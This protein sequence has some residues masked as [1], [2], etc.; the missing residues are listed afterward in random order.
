MD[1]LK[2]VKGNTFETVVEIRAYKYNGEEITDF[3]LNNCTN[4]S[5]INHV[6]N[7]ETYRIVNYE[8]LDEKHIQMRWD[9]CV[10]GDYSLEVTGKLG[11]DYWRFYDKKPIFSIVN[12]NAE[13]HIPQNSIIREDCYQV[14]KQKVYIVCPKGDKGDKGDKGA[15]GPT[16][17]NG[18]PFKYEDFTQEQLNSLKGK[19]GDPG[20]DGKD[21]SDGKSAYELAVE[22]GYEGTLEQWLNSL[23]GLD[24][25]DGSNGK[26]AY[27][28]YVDTTSDDPV[29]TEEQWIA[30]LHGV[31]GSAFTYNDFTPAQLAVLKGEPGKDGH[32]PEIAASKSGDTTTIYLDGTSIATINDGQDGTN[33]VSPTISVSQI[34]GGGGHTVTITDAQGTSSF[35]VMDGSLANQ[36]KSNWSETDSSSAAFILNKPALATV[37]TSGDY[38]DLT[39]TPDLS[40]YLTSHQS[41]SSKQDVIDSSHKLSADL[42][43]DTNSTNKFTNATEKQTW[44][45]K[46]DALTFNSTPSSSNKVATMADIPAAFSGDYND[47][48]N[49]PTIPAAQVQSDWNVSDSSSLAYIAN[50]PNV[51]TYSGNI[52]LTISVVSQLPQQPDANTIYIVQ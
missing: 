16:G 10:V 27:Q 2:I 11:D 51:V 13:A 30:S 3:D 23:H 44:N 28:S 1:K 21:G 47:L 25:T 41:L 17:K 52:P 29:L 22:N 26:S 8:I 7:G 18:D 9:R 32:S 19:Q 36:I 31:D 6:S 5:I 39:N 38:S 43:D 49:K 35:N 48:S 42:V 12:T 4:I 33:G 37:A 34:P 14:D 50:K 45:G 46:Q 24:G 15:T 40:V 20:N